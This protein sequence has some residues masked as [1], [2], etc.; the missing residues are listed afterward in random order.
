MGTM[1]GHGLNTVRPDATPIRYGY[2]GVDSCE[3]SMITGGI[4]STVQ[5]RPPL[6][7]AYVLALI[8]VLLAI[9]TAY[10]LFRLY[11]T[12]S[13]LEDADKKA[14][15]LETKNRASILNNYF[16]TR[17]HE[18]RLFCKN[19]AFQKYYDAQTLGISLQDGLG[20]MTGQMEQQLLMVRLETQ[21][22]GRPVYQSAAFFDSGSG[23]ILART[24]FSARGRWINRDLFNSLGRQNSRQVTFA[25]FCEGE[26][27]RLF[28]VG[29][30]MHGGREKGLLLLELSSETLLSK[31]QVVGLEKD[32]D[33]TGLADHNGTLVLG[34]QWLIGRKLQDTLG[35]T[36]ESFQKARLVQ[37][38]RRNNPAKAK[39]DAMAEGKALENRFLLI[40]L[41]P[42]S[43]HAEGHTQLLWPAVFVSLMG[44]LVL[45]LV[46]ISRS[47]AERNLM[48][49][50]LQEAHDNLEQRVSERTAELEQLNQTLRLEIAERQR[51]EKA[52]LRAS[53]DLEIANTEL[54]D[55]AYIVSHDLKAPLRAVSQLVG[56]LAADY[57]HAFDDEGKENLGLLLN[58][59]T[60]MHN[61]I[62]SILHYSRL[63]RTRDEMTEVDLNRL[64]SEV[65]DMVSPPPHIT[66]TVEDRLPIVRCEETRIQEL[67]Q[68]L[69]D[70]AIK[71]MD[72]PDGQ[73]RIGCLQKDSHWQCRVSDNGPGIEEK[74][75]EKIF[76]IFQTLQSR[77][78]MEST[79]IGLTVVKKIVE[80]HGGEVWIESRLGS[81]TTFFFTLP[82]LREES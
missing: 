47:Q 59:V 32:D 6:S 3:A 81:G 80:L 77:D 57:A 42:W 18:V 54:K 73:I 21:D 7:S 56:W 5:N 39:S 19:E 30:V 1:R 16:R 4:R 60:R 58:R 36:S 76:Q 61:L 46:H 24:D 44:G 52:L 27:C 45:V 40:H 66:V 12:S 65:I 29:R 8:L 72:K 28:A 14:F 78:E 69:L 51:A 70:N 48:Y 79:G 62:D 49:E 41:A 34:P 53:Q 37:V 38:P 75:H 26:S 68:N 43:K 25:S 10:M 82:V 67:F 11:Q 64:V 20:V 15:I 63:G 71:Y 74:Y 22:Q 13:L 50:K 23:S 33:F 17:A 35:L 9:T 55:F 2:R 31:V